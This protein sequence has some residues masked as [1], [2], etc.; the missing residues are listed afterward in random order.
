MSC[1]AL[2]PRT[3]YRR[4]IFSIQTTVRTFTLQRRQSIV[5]D[6]SRADL[7]YPPAPASED[8]ARKTDR[9]RHLRLVPSPE[10]RFER[11]LSRYRGWVRST[12][13]K[14]SSRRLTADLEDLEQEVALRLWRQIQGDKPI[15]NPASYLYQIASS[16][17]LDALRRISRSPKTASASLTD[18]EDGADVL[19]FPSSQPDPE[20]AVAATLLTDCVRR[21]HAELP[22]NRRRAV[23]LYLQGFKIEEVADLAGWSE[24]K[25]RNL[26]YRGLATLRERLKGVDGVNR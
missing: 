22:E 1:G 19:E 18:D 16:A 20:R 23:G 21:F 17:T 15:E 11:L 7:G 6:L 9:S 14:L 8:V 2:F 5:R 4:P 25:A 24:P 10:D 26:I 13:R 3:Y 12:L